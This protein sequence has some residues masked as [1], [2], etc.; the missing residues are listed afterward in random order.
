MRE[1]MEA[2]LAV[3][4]HE[5]AVGQAQVQQREQQLASLR[6]TLLRIGGAILVLEE[7]LSCTAAAITMDQDKPHPDDLPVT[8][9]RLDLVKG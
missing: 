7:L 8:G 6:E 5:F 9:G 2:R 3:L 4:K 1:K